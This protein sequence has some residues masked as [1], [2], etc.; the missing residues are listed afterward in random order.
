[1]SLHPP[2]HRRDALH[3]GSNPFLRHEFLGALELTHCVT[4]ARGWVPNIITLRDAVGLAAAAPAYIK[5]NSYG[6]FVF[7]FGWAQAYER[8][9]LP[10]YPKLVIGVPF[11]PVTGP[12]LLVRRD[13][14][15]AATRRA[16]VAAIAT[17]LT[18]HNWSSAHLLF[19][20]E[21]DIRAA[22]D[23]GWLSRT[24]CQFHWH[25]QGY[26]DFEH[27]LQTFSSA[28]RIKTRRER[29]RVAAAGVVFETRH[30]AELTE[31]ELLDA[32]ALITGTFNQRGME[33]YVTPQLL[34]ESA[35]AAGSQLMLQIA[36]QDAQMVGV[37]VFFVG[38]DTLYGRYWGAAR[39]IDCLHFETCYYRGIDYCIANNLAHF[40]PG[41]QG[42]HKIARGFGPAISQSAHLIADP[43]FRQA[44]RD[45]VEREAAGVRAY[46]RDVAAHLPYREL[47]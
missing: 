29:R 33:P 9:G 44:I 45:F 37:A 21:A 24:D 10:Y 18:T 7:D 38:T 1:M 11:T 15:A 30:G 16:L 14:D 2:M 23:A 20:C 19:G 34:L 26:R 46:A 5:R 17:E 36:R 42:E 35:A 47:P 4:A 43:R 6:E 40:D 39:P 3:D 41:V 13:L 8:M 28:K 12:R 25:N 22:R 31:Q 32:H 27:F